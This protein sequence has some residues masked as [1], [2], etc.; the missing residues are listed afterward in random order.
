MTIN[1]DENDFSRVK[2]IDPG[3]G[4]SYE[5]YNATAA[6]PYSVSVT[7]PGPFVYTNYY[8]FN[9]ASPAWNY[10]DTITTGMP[11]TFEAGAG[12]DLL[13]STEPTDDFYGRL[14]PTRFFGGEGDDTINP[15][16]DTSPGL[17][18]SVEAYGGG[19]NDTING[20][21]LND[22]LHG[23][24]ANSFT[25]DP[26]IASVTLAP[27]DTS[28]DGNDVISGYGGNDAISGDGGN[29][30]LFGGT[31]A[32]TLSG[33]AGN[34][35]LFGGPRGTGDL[36]VLTGGSGADTFLL[37]YSQDSAN[38]GAGFWGDYLEQAGQNIAGNAANSIIADAIK[39]AAEDGVAAG[40]IADGL[41]AVG[42]QLV[43]SFI[44]LVE[45]LASADQP[46]TAQD[47]MVVTDFDPRE[48]VLVLPLQTTVLESLTVNVVTASQIPGGGPSDEKVLSF[49]AGGKDY[50]YVQLS[51]GFLHDMGLQGTG[52][53]TAQI[54]NNLVNFSSAIAAS[55]GK[56]GF[57]NLA[58]SISDN[59]S[60]GG[61]QPQDGD[62][63]PGSSVLLYGAIGG[64]VIDG[65]PTGTSYGSILAGTN[66][67]DALSTNP[68]ILD[69]SR[70]KDFAATGAY[71]H[72]FGGDDLIYGTSGPDTLFGDDGNDTLYSFVTT[73]SSN[74][75]DPE[76]LS[77]GAGNDTLYGGGSAGNFDGGTGND[78]F[79][80]VYS[81]NTSV[82]QLEVDL[83]TGQAAE[84]A[85]QPDQS[86]PVSETAPFSFDVPEHYTLTSIE[87]A[88]GGPANDWLKG[89][90]GSAIEGGPGAD[91]LDTTATGVDVSYASSQDGV[92]VQLFTD[93][94]VTS[95]GDAQGDVIGYGAIINV[96]DLIGSQQGDTL[97]AQFSQPG[98]LSLT[99]NGGSDV[100]QILG[101]GGPSVL[102]ITDFSQADADKI[103]LR[104][105]GITSMADVDASGQIIQI[106]DQGQL[107]QVN[108][109]SF[110]GTISASDFLFAS[111]V[112]SIG[113][114]DRG[115]AGLVGS[116][117]DDVL[118]GREGG[119]Y[120]FGEGGNDVLRG[121]GGN[122]VLHGGD[123]ADKL[124]G[125]AGTDH[126][127][128]GAGDDIL[129]GGRGDDLLYGGPGADR[130]RGGAGADTFFLRFGETN[131]DKVL[132]FSRADGDRLSVASNS[133]ITVT[134]GSQGS[135]M[136]SDGH[137]TE[138]LIAKGA[139]VSDF[140][141]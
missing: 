99:G 39:A 14:A 57:T 138:T 125:Q 8:V 102:T 4:L 21:N 28:N 85:L 36:D 5:L 11:G 34:D 141:V 29:D 64:M 47:A 45:S 96:N 50:A 15:P 10:P 7:E 91:Y 40:F 75:N 59:L 9:L 126:L 92:T 66:F 87:N 32:D 81:A 72:G 6:S 106:N 17:I 60:D 122:D 16:Q 101:V 56:A 1:I 84:R 33:G 140:A 115:G 86:A 103:D 134:G 37:S 124:Q 12:N 88:I 90:T 113:V 82:Q 54:L 19:G 13:V 74:G 123:G 48:D 18:Y 65:G 121:R 132:D 67:S 111:P 42:G 136:L 35:F 139:T 30:Q 114:A 31:G 58:T 79:G 137:V 62:L 63:P 55:D 38:A 25:G 20:S 128:G 77:G 51:D 89:A 24:T 83:T 129:V 98:F 93:G 49:E 71:I 105:L 112:S 2:N 116:A 61:F 95:G 135:F 26:V 94:S 73:Q 133:A 104:P 117:G 78:T 100:F 53:G 69:P 43:T 107:I 119:D 3:S 41:G 27:Y 80:V 108:L 68:H 44:S 22:T 127:D 131:G 23:D 118:R 46:Q 130:M 109:T 52:N 97:G 70:M 110:S 76:S 120:L